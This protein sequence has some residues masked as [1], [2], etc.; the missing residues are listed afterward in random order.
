[1][2]VRKYQELL[3]WQKAIALVTDVYEVTRTFLADGQGRAS[4]GEF[5]QFLCHARGSLFE[6]ETQI[7]LA[8]KLDYLSDEQRDGRMERISEV[9]R[10]LNGVISSLQK[11]KQQQP[12]A[13]SNQ[14]S[15]TSH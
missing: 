8:G 5:L 6:I 1:M 7:I 11:R 12:L 10:I 15:A 3:A 13:T 9:G 14:P 2:A 4:S